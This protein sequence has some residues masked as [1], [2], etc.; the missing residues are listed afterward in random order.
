[1]V[2]KLQIVFHLHPI[3]IVV[4]VLR[5]LFILVQQLRSVATSTAVNAVKLIATAGLIAI[6][7]T[8]AAIISIIIQGNGSSSAASKQDY[9]YTR[10]P[11]TPCL[12][13]LPSGVAHSALPC[14]RT[15]A[16][17][18]FERIMEL[19][20]AISALRRS[21]ELI[22]ELAGLGRFANPLRN[23]IDEEQARAAFVPDRASVPL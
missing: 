23:F 12:C 21:S 13:A 7:A 20:S 19:G 3:A 18:S 16:K 1:M 8:A 17:G 15:I 6:A 2:G 5:K 4:G 14:L 9:F 11:Q 10:G 22:L